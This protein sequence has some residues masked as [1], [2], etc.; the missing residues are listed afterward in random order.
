MGKPSHLLANTGRVTLLKTVFKRRRSQCIPYLVLSKMNQVLATVQGPDM[1][2]FFQRV[3]M[4][5][6]REKTNTMII[7]TISKGIL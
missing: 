4:K 6:E 2:V 1:A 7:F 3:E 5:S